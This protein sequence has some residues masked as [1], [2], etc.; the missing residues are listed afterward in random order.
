MPRPPPRPRGNNTNK[1]SSLWTVG[2]PLSPPLFPVDLNDNNDEAKGDEEDNNDDDDFEKNHDEE[3]NG[4]DDKDSDSEYVD[5]EKNDDDL[6]DDDGEKV[7]DEDRLKVLSELMDSDLLED[8][9]EPQS[10]RCDWVMGL[11][12]GQKSNRELPPIPNYAG[13][14]E[15]EKENAKKERQKLIKKEY[16]RARKLSRSVAP[17]REDIVYTGDVSE[18][19]RPMTHV[20]LHPL[21]EGHTFPRNKIALQLRIV[22]EANLFGVRITFKRSDNCQVLAKGNKIDPFIVSATYV[23]KTQSWIVGTCITRS[24]RHIY[25]PPEKKDRKTNCKPKDQLP[26]VSVHDLPPPEK[27]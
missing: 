11:N 6:S 19:L 21:E 3:H 24:G 17:M 22:E 2:R 15:H 8:Q 9:C 1:D 13:M 27:K 26:P 16:D 14:S 7:P 10:Y 4:K 20:R 12:A 25:V 18:K 23:S 5:Q